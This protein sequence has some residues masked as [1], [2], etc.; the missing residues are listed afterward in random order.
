MYIYIYIYIYNIYIYIYIYISIYTCSVKEVLKQVLE[1]DYKC[2]QQNRGI[3]L[4]LL[5]D[6]SN[7]FIVLLLIMNIIL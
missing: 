6:I 1:F 5:K 3:V 7:M 4:T 2:L